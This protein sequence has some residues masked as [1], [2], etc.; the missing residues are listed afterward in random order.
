MTKSMVFRAAVIWLGIVCFAV[1]NGMVRD[2][3]VAPRLGENFAL[4]LSGFILSIIVFV[5]A[6]FSFSFMGAKTRITC[7]FIGIQWVLMTLTFEFVFG[8]FVVGKSWSD[9]I[10]VFNVARGNLFLL[11]L[12]VSF[13]SPSIVAKTKGVL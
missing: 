2:E 1:V 4:P 9:L 3:I 5:V 13:L 8:H 7:V 6:Y 10:Q 11:V 12:F